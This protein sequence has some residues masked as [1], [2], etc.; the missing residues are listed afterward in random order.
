MTIRRFSPGP[1]CLGFGVCGDSVNGSLHRTCEAMSE[2][3][4][5]QI[6]GVVF[7]TGFGA[8]MDV[9]GGALWERSSQALLPIPINPRLA[10]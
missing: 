5:G 9:G 2:L 7:G 8:W 6:V 3:G 10:K 4:I 1:S